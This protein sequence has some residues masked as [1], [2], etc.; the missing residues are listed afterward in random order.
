MFLVFGGTTEGK[1]VAGLLDHLGE[2]Y[3]Y[4]TKS[5]TQVKISGQLITGAKDSQQIIQLCK[6]NAVNLIIDAAH[7]FAIDLHKNITTAADFLKIPCIRFERTYPSIN[8]GENIRFFSSWKE[9]TATLAASNY[10]TILALTGVQTIPYYEQLRRNHECFFRIL[11]TQQ[12]NSLATKYGIDEKHILARHPNSNTDE[13]ISLIRET[14]AEVLTSKES[15]DSGF[16]SSKI[17]A[18]EQ[19]NIPLWIIQ[20]PEL[21]DYDHKVESVKSLLQTIYLLKRKISGD[22]NALRSGFTTGT[23]VTAA[24]KACFIALHEQQFPKSVCVT[25]PHGE[26]TDFLIFPERLTD[27]SASCLVIKDAGDD[28]DVT[29]AKEI[30]CEITLTNEAGIRFERGKGIGEVTLP[31]LQVAVGEPAINPVPRKM[32][33]ELLS[34]LSEL[35]EDYRGLIVK[36][37]VPEGEELAKK[38]FN[39]RVG[40]VGG[41]SII[42]TSGKVI[43]F[44]NEAFLASIKQQI[45]VAQQS[46]FNEVVLCSGKR[47]E[48]ILQKQFNH[49]PSTNFIHYGNLVGDTLKLATDSGIKKIH[50]GMML[51]KA[52]KLAEGHLNTHSKHNNFNA[53]FAAQIAADCSYHES[54]VN[55][56]RE[57]TLA[58]AIRDLISFSNNETFYNEI[59]QRCY[60]QCKDLIQ[61]NT[62]FSFTL[63][64]DSEETI[65]IP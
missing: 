2:L 8:E 15:G 62:Q 31:G 28:P 47:S 26:S 60:R 23:C 11:P 20:R 49:L 4:S 21:P 44:S 50:L 42:G 55:A 29:H 6:Q 51:G 14:K 64:V 16:I 65:C 52:I 5:D 63:I 10:N 54:I 37:F 18:A 57:L 1:K 35:Y 12:S 61:E 40:V 59:A 34:E 33:I 48:Q 17:E 24:A 56:I 53:E 38:T 58:N 7:P 25:L 32:L 36:P 22:K 45:A 43:P 30:G 39:P 13:L 27:S 41:I 46:E 9:M 3:L 19:L